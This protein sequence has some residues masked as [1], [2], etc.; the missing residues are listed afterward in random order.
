MWQG[1]SVCL[2]GLG[3]G[4]DLAQSEPPFFAIFPEARFQGEE[5]FLSLFF[6]LSFFPC[7]LRQFYKLTTAAT[8][9]NSLPEEERLEEEERRSRT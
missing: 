7:L 2:T 8:T 5:V 9:A 1:L 4:W 3:T 6:F